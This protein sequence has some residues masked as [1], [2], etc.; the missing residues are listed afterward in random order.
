[1]LEDSCVDKFLKLSQG[2]K[3]KTDMA[4]ARNQ[5]NDLTAPCISRCWKENE[6]VKCVP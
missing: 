3:V 2:K 4:V 1:M 5:H 6:N